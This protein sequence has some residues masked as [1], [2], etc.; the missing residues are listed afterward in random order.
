MREHKTLPAFTITYKFS[1]T[2][3]KHQWTSG[4]ASVFTLTSPPLPPLFSQSISL[5]L[6]LH[7]LNSLGR[8][9]HSPCSP[10]TITNAWMHT[11]YIFLHSFFSSHVLV[12]SFKEAP[13]VAFTALKHP[14]AALSKSLCVFGGFSYCLW[15]YKCT[16][17]RT[18]TQKLSGLKWGSTCLCP[19]EIFTAI[20]NR[21][22]HTHPATFRQLENTRSQECTDLRALTHSHVPWMH[23]KSTLTLQ[24]LTCQ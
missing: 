11:L 7:T 2:A 5:P 14:T 22:S 12:L 18:D 13:S 16:H 20:T 15:S 21:I 1:S 24:A 9:L 23:F 17:T 10:R 4:L 3:M 6:F 19:A 8:R